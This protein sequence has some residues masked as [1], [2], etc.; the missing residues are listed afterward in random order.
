MGKNIKISIPHELSPAEV[1][2]RLVE[3]LADARAK[4]PDLLRD[5]HETWSNDNEM[6]FTGHAMGQRITGSVE[7]KPGQ[8]HATIILPLLL[9]MFAAKLKPRIEAEGQKLF[10]G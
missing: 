2:Q 10:E 8:V 4:H 7:I 3:A 9:A 6:H 5:A 1:K